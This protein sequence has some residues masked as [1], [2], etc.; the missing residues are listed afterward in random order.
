MVVLVVHRRELD[1]GRDER[2]HRGLATK[3][4]E[5]KCTRI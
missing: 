3:Q 4:Y 2:H 5:E 1:H